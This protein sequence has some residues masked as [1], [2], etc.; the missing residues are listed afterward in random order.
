MTLFD[1]IKKDPNGPSSIFILIMALLIFI[2]PWAL[3]KIVF[4]VALGVVFGVYA[5]KGPLKNFINHVKN[6]NHCKK[7]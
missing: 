1:D 3:A 6:D 2:V 4:A 7:D 5:L